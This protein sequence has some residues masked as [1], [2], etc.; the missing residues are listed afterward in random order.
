MQTSGA[1]SSS[2]N[3]L[4]SIGVSITRKTVNRKK[5]LISNK[6]QQTADDYYLQNIENIFILNIDNYHN[7]HKCN[8]LTLL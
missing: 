2:I 7:I 3:T 1:S 4:A 8:Q 6:Y 5:N